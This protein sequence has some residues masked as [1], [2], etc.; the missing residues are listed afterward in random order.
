MAALSASAFGFPLDAWTRAAPGRLDTPGL[1]VSVA[2]RSDEPVSTVTTTQAGGVV[3][4]WT[5]GTPPEHQ[6]R[7]AGRAV[8]THAL[9]HHRQ[10]GGDLFYLYATAAGR[11]LYSSVGFTTVAEVPTCVRGHST[12]V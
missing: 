6:R 11:P 10:R 8:L 12:Q 4:V 5:M 7:G 9:R 3:G 1:T 2:Y